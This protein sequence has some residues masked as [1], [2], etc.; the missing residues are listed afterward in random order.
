MISSP[1]A[2]SPQSLGS[3]AMSESDDDAT[4]NDAD[5]TNDASSYPLEGKFKDTVD[6]ANIMAMSEIQREEILA[7]RAQEI[8]RKAQD[9]Q[10]RRLLQQ[11][12]KS[13]AKVAEKKRKAGTA[14][15]EESPR[16]TT[17]AKAK[18]SADLENYKRQ[19]EQRNEQRRRDDER[20]A[21]DGPRS[22]SR[23]RELSDADH[24]E[25]DEVEWDDRPTRPEV[26]RQEPK[27]ELRDFQRVT[28]GRSNFAKVCFTPGFDEAIKGCFCRVNIGPDR[29]SGQNQYRMTQIK[30]IT[31]S[32]AFGRPC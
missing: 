11:R 21:R 25:A 12:E 20:R 5:T 7:E 17:R 16:K 19:R 27:A 24:G 6:K 22:P 18:A 30:G 9:L 10:L 29:A 2:K 15:L 8:E 26:R 23:D 32:Q 31:F 28:V 1:E 13:S 3:G 4:A 14:D